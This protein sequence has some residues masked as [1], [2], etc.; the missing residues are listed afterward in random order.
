MN[1]GKTFYDITP[2]TPK[3]AVRLDDISDLPL[4]PEAP[5]PSATPAP[6]VNALP[7]NPTQNS[8]SNPAPISTPASAPTARAAAPIAPTAAAATPSTAA[9]LSTPTAAA[10][11]SAAAAPIAPAKPNI[12]N[13]PLTRTPIETPR[14]TARH[15]TPWLRD[16]VGLA[17]FVAVIIIGAWLINLLVFRSFNVLGPSMEPTLEGE[18]SSDRLIVNILPVTGAHLTGKA[19]VPSRG[20]IIVFRN[21]NFQPGG[22]DEYIVKRVVGLPGERV[23]VDG[24][25]LKVYNKDH[26]DGFNPYPDF[27]NFASND[28]DINTC[29]DGGGTDVTVP[30]DA[31]FVVGDHRVGNYSMDSRNGGGRASLGTI[32]LD[33]IIGPVSLRIWP[34]DKLKI[35]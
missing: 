3:T 9:A 29:V 21:P 10:P 30:D 19:Y 34:L 2:P 23:T 13:T 5:T 6:I 35:F 12:P 18:G 26:P 33:D 1:S 4:P 7:P 17:V 28:G 20:Q 24:C 8:L 22:A 16:I 27:K 25:V 14:P 15:A 32:P 11:T 31:I